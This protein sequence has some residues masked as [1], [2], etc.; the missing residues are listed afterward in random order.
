MSTIVDYARTSRDSFVERPLGRVDSLCLSWLA[1]L[2]FPEGLGIEGRAGLRLLDLAAL[3]Y[4]TQMTAPIHD[5][6]ESGRLFDALAASLR[7]SQVR[8]CLHVAE[9]S[10]AEGMQ[11]SAT[12]FVL[13]DGAGSCVC[14]R[15]TD[16]TVLGWKE[17]FHFACAGA[18]PAQRRAVRYLE[19]AICELGGRF[20]VCGHSKGGAL[21]AYAAGMAN[22]E[23]RAHI[24]ACCSHDG[25]GLCP[26]I[27]ADPAWHG[28]V[29]LDK[30]VPH[31]SLVGMLFERSQSG[32]AVVRSTAEGV[33]QHAPFTWEVT[34]KDFVY[35]QGMSYDAWRTAQRINDWLEATSPSDRVAFADMLAW[36][37]DATGEQS[38]SG[39]LARW[40]SNAQAMRAALAGA[41]AQDRELFDRVTDELVTTLVLGSAQEHARAEAGTREASDAAARRVEDLTARAND[42]FSKL[43][44]LTGGR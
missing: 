26:E 33:M 4:T 3:G 21:A 44:R 19:D 30:T 6:S 36:L 40:G 25:P 23:T 41:P 18:I 37:A 13:P 43:D 11:F 9:S 8:A 7:F 29:P 17:N 24:T 2:R 34:G 5:A 1:Y 22:D 20:W 31:E 27:T 16:D 38:C 28:D 14:F 15:G 35:E 12:T 42:H 39:L 32:L 10:E